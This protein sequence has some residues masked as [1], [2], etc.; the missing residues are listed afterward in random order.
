VTQAPASPVPPSSKPPSTEPPV[1]GLVFP[2]FAYPFTP[3]G[4]PFASS[5]KDTFELAYYEVG[6]AATTRDSYFRDRDTG[7]N[8]WPKGSPVVY[9]EVTVTNIG[10]GSCYVSVAGPM[11]VVALKS[12]DYLGGVSTLAP[13]DTPT[14][15][16]FGVH[17]NGFRTQGYDWARG[18]HFPLGPGQSIAVAVPLPLRTGET[19]RFTPLMYHYSR[20]EKADAGLAVYFAEATTVFT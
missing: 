6:R 18:D 17:Q 1:G 5:R 4:P 12:L 16:R 20:V 19:Y 2:A 8:L 11:L 13:F 9:I 7:R 14:A 3:A 15:D 10:A